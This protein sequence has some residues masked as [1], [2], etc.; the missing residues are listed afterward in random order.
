M[1]KK[2]DLKCVL[3]GKAAVGKSC[4]VERFL[5]NKWTSEQMP[6]V[7][8]AFGAK[9][10][11]IGKRKVMLGVWD[12]AGSERYEAMTR[13]YYKGAE[14]AVICY[15]L[16]DAKSWEK[17]KFW[18][19]EILA[20]E[21]NCILAIVGTKSDLLAK[22]QR[23]GVDRS[24]VTKYAQQINATEYETSSLTGENVETP[25]VN[26]AKE[27]NTR[28][29]GAAPPDPGTVNLSPQTSK[30]SGSS[31][32]GGGGFC[33]RCGAV[34]HFPGD[35]SSSST[36]AGK[37]CYAVAKGPNLKTKHSLLAQDGRQFCFNFARFGTCRFGS[38]CS[39]FHGCSICQ[40]SSHGAGSCNS[41][42]A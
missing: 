16:T 39:N 12:T 10:I 14:A 15:D 42:R 29:R 5:H 33:F 25:F 31:G 1:Q 17:V 21:E 23:R 4:L 40:S 22:G 3:L 32:S 41:V 13:H 24:V 20:I 11:T 38:G 34:G 9:D 2:V 19:N 18:V 7:G 27:W 26:I 37:Q 30:G 28:P 36:V 8:A 6:T 35:C